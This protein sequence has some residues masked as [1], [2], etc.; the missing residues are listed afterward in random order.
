MYE[1]VLTGRERA[2]GP[3]HPTPCNR[4]T[5]SLKPTGPR[6]APRRLRMRT[7]SLL[8]RRLCHAYRYLPIPLLT[9]RNGTH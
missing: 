8:I 4:A 3:D 5:T 1:Q 7:S 6:A 2:L 9:C